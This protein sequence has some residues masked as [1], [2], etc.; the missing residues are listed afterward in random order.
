MS[1]KRKGNTQKKEEWELERHALKHR[2][3]NLLT[4]FHFSPEESR[5][6]K[7][8]LGVPVDFFLA[9]AAIGG[10]SMAEETIFHEERAAR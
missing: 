2:T 8:I 5:R 6:L 10:L 9:L 3:S 7:R 1:S 4:H